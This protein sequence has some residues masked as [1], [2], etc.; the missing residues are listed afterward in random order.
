MPDAALCLGADAESMSGIAY[1]LGI[2]DVQTVSDEASP[3][4][5]E[6]I[7]GGLRDMIAQAQPGDT[8]LFTYAGHGGESFDGSSVVL[9][10]NDGPVTEAE[11]RA[12][13]ATVPEGVQLSMILDSDGDM[14]DLS[15]A[16]AEEDIAGEVVCFSAASDPSS[17]AF[18]D[19]LAGILQSNPGISWHEAALLVDDAH[20][21]VVSSNHPEA[22][23]APAF[24]NCLS[25]AAA[26]ENTVF[27]SADLTDADSDQDDD[28]PA[29]SASRGH[30]DD[31]AD[32]TDALTS[33]HIH[34]TDALVAM[35]VPEPTEEARQI[36]AELTEAHAELDA[37]LPPLEPF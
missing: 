13:L 5:R 28:N 35:D 14:V 18:S 26:D 9:T 25:R 23:F 37:L 20:A 4:T 21:P 2:E 3:V 27:V 10:A 8:L 16:L 6:M 12:V 29:D 30:G 7:L 11:L 19:A 17:G 36:A 1:G 33:L 15:N 32:L 22:I 31:H 34:G 24:S